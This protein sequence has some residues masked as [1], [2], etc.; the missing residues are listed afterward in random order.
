MSLRD[1]PP[2]PSS[3]TLAATIREMGSLEVP[4]ARVVLGDVTGDVRELDF[5]AKLAMSLALELLAFVRQVAL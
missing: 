1:N 3:F 2:M 5:D 4:V